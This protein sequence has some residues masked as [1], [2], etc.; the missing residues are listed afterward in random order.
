MSTKEKTVKVE[1]PYCG[2]RMPVSYSEGAE[3]RGLFIT[4]K[5]R[6]CKKVFE[7][8]IEKGQQVK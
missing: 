6:N 3:S 1:C 4:C 7:I 8:K 2:Y 5:G